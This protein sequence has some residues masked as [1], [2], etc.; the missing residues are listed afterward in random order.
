MSPAALSRPST[1]HSSRILIAALAAL[2]FVALTVAAPAANAQEAPVTDEQTL[3]DDAIEEANPSVEIEKATNG[4]DADGA[5]GPTVRVTTPVAWTYTVTNTGN[6]PLTNVAVSDDNIDGVPLVCPDD[7]LAPQ[8]SMECTAS[9]V[10]W[11]LRRLTTHSNLA[12]VVATFEEQV[13]ADEDR[14]HYTP[15]RSV[16][17]RPTAAAS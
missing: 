17:F 1:A 3:P 6:V 10:S 9:S 15:T 4:H 12:S 8:E 2:L 13:V 5:P 16:L 11:G 14:S 7:S